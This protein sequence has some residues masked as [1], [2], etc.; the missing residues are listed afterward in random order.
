VGRGPPWTQR[1]LPTGPVRPP[2][3]LVHH[4]G[5]P[6]A[7]QNAHPVTQ[8]FHFRNTVRRKENRFP[9][10]I[11]AHESVP[12]FPA[13]PG[14]QAPSPVRPTPSVSDREAWTGPRRCAASIPFEYS[15]MARPAFPVI[16][17]WATTSSMRAVKLVFGNPRQPPIKTQHFS[18]A[19]YL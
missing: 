16:R 9:F 12:A 17:T 11:Q 8:L 15:R 4:S 6:T 18:T 5:Q 13:T 7:H 14:V 2:F 1:F 10:L 3:R 19:Q